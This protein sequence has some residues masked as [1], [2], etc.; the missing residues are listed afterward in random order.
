MYD[1]TSVQSYPFYQEVI[2]RTG[3]EIPIKNLALVTQYIEELEE[4]KP[5]FNHHY[6]QRELKLWRE[7]ITFNHFLKKQ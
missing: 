7:K 4:E 6:L 5:G 1:E 2:K 3:K